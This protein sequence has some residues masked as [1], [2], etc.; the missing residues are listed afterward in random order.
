MKVRYLFLLLFLGLFTKH[1]S[2]SF[3]EL[4]IYF[5]QF[6]KDPLLSSPRFGESQICDFVIG[7]R[8]NS[9]NFGGVNTSI[10][11]VSCKLK[12][13][14]SGGFNEVGVNFLNDNE[15]FL[16]KRNRAYLSVLRHT[17]LNDNYSLAG[18]VALGF[19]NFTIKPDGAFGGASDAALDGGL[20]LKLYN[21]KSALNLVVNQIFNST[22]Q[23]VQQE[24]ILT[25]NYNLS[26][27]RE[28]KIS[29]QITNYSNVLLRWSRVSSLQTSGFVMAPNTQFLFADLVLTGVTFESKKGIYYS[30]GMNKIPGLDAD[31]GF[32]ISYLVPFS[33]S[34]V[35]N[36]NQFEITINYKILKK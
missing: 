19:Y 26:Y 5:G 28:T 4:P 8:R 1:Y 13:N 2:Q 20:R 35:S 16:I 30:A 32:E 36:L 17:K 27:N 7:H 29:D 25:N 3:D 12:P 22:I 15:G 23:P 24:I 18:G 31:F 9:N 21:N 11:G 14:S 10:F 34:L 6:Y 33:K